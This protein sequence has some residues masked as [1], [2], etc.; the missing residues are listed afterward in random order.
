MPFDH[1]FDDAEEDDGGDSADPVPGDPACADTL[2]YI[3][4]SLSTK[5]LPGTFSFA[6]KRMWST[7]VIVRK[8]C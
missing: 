1:D 3:K 6:G 5:V 4:S 2:Q 8:T 7:R